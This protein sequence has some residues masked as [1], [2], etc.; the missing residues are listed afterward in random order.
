ME[1]ELTAAETLAAATAQAAEWG[2]GATGAA[3]AAAEWA[4]WAKREEAGKNEK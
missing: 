3:W 2:W 4:E 1:N